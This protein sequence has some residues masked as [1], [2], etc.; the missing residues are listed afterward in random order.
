MKRVGFAAAWL[1][2]AVSLWGQQNDAGSNGAP[3]TSVPELIERLRDEEAD[4]ELRRRAA[5]AL[6]KFGPL[7]KSAT[8]ELLAV[9]NHQSL[10]LGLYALDAIGRIGPDAAESVPDVLAAMNRRNEM[11]AK[12]S[13]WDDPHFWLTAMRTFGRIGPG[14]KSAAP[15][16]EK[17]LKSEDPLQRVAAA[18][19]LWK[20]ERRPQ[21][22]G[23]LIEIIGGSADEAAYEAIM[24]LVDCGTDAETVVPPLVAALGHQAA[25]VRRAAAKGLGSLGL[26]A[27]AA[28]A[29]ARRENKDL[30]LHAA[31]VAL[32]YVARRI[33]AATRD[34]PNAT[35][36]EVSA[37]ATALA[38]QAVPVLV[39][40]LHDPQPRTRTAGVRALSWLG[41][42]AT[43]QLLETLRSDSEVA[44][45][46]AEETLIRVG[47]F[48]PPKTLSP[49]ALDWL[50]K[51]VAPSLIAGASDEDLLVRT[52][53]ARMLAIFPLGEHGRDALP[54]LREALKDPDVA[55]RGH[56]LKALE[57][58][59]R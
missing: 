48:L 24:A 29:E 41:V 17:F 47:D 12:D 59:Q 30:D 55:L 28:V 2:A 16:V 39:Q 34:R 20:I 53:A 10:P 46:S 21:S 38:E 50:R 5:Y 6:G 49:E 56:A 33:R 25:D 9:L 3:P 27:V 57:L 52:A 11:I 44:R 22:I 31:A 4:S 18:A 43:P 14:A 37:T 15:V 1:C 40:A 26:P 8:P 19:S 36:D 7:A 54:A 13:N 51:S 23:T 45:Q 42:S 35:A 32:G 58:Y